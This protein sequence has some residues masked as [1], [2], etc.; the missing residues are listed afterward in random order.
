VENFT[1]T[2]TNT[3]IFAG[4]AREDL[5]RV[6]GNLDEVGVAAGVAILRQG[7]PGD[8]L[9]VVQSGAVEI[10]HASEDGVV[11]RIAILGPC[12]CFGEIALFT[13]APRTATVV[14]LVDT[15]LLRLS[16]ASCE[17]LV[18]QCPAFS[19]HVCRLLGERLVERGRELVQSRAGRD[20][21]LAELFAAQPPATRTLLLMTAVL[22][23]VTPEAL[24][25]VV[26]GQADPGVLD[27]LA[28]RYPR[29]VQADDQGGWTLQ[30]GFRAF[31]LGRLVLDDGA[32][33]AVPLHARVAAHF[34]ARHDWS[35]AV[36]DHLGA[37]AWEAAIH[38]LERHGDAFLAQEA[39]PHVLTQ[40]DALPPALV[41]PRFHLV[42]LRAKAHA[43]QGNLEAALR[44]CRELRAPAHAGSPGAVAQAFGYHVGLAELHRDKGQKAE[45]LRSLRD[46][47]AVL[48][49]SQ[50]RRA[51]TP[52]LRLPRPIIL[53]RHL[54]LQHHWLYVV[55]A[56]AAGLVVWHLPPPAALD[57]AGMRFL[58]TLTVA[59]VLWSVNV[60]DD[61]VVALGL[62]VAWIAAGIVRPEVA[63]S[64]FTKPSWFLFVGALGLGAGVTRS[65]LL[66][67]AALAM[68]R[69]VT[70]SYPRYTAILAAAEVLATPAL[71][72][73]ISRM[74]VV[75]PVS[76][77]IA[78]SVG[79]APR[80][81][82]AAG[83]VFATFVGFSLL[84]FAFLTGS[85]GGLLGW[86]V[87]PEAARVQFGW[88]AWAVAAAPAGV[89][90]L[91]GLWLAIHLLFRLP[92]GG[93][94]RGSR[95]RFQA[96]IEI[97]GPFT[98]REACS[99]GVLVLA[100]TG[101]STTSL[102]G[103]GEAWVA[104]GALLLCLLGGVLDR[105]SLRANVDLGF[106]LF[107][108]VVSSL[109]A[110]VT[111]VQADRWLMTLVSPVLETAAVN[112]T[113]LLLTVALVNI[114]VRFVLNKFAA[115]ILLTL[116]L[117]P[118]GAQL[119]VH[120][121]VVLL[122]IL[123]TTDVWFFPYQLDVYQIAY[124]GTGEQGFTHAQGRQLM[125]AKLVVALVAIVISVP[126]W[127]L[128]GL[129]RSE[130][131]RRGTV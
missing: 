7:D 4:L 99:L 6:A 110:V 42:R 15:S 100:I 101:W 125:V 131:W 107:L 108:G 78:E 96:Q 41:R 8:A 67:R 52:V 38:V 103:V 104:L 127:R 114:T 93:E 86:N 25:P 129:I 102:H 89:I 19:L 83:L 105:G 75:A 17:Q 122:V 113:T 59:L 29:L 54:G 119:G 109:S 63:L 60:F 69:R 31:L 123:L 92:P 3:P 20:A 76:W 121:G 34:E 111:A 47:L 26:D 14:A 74:A 44:G 58:A 10:L 5:A 68:V 91:G 39:P 66:Y 28:E 11:E 9:Y 65:G 98:R 33:A 117:A 55:F 106:L 77:A 35:R 130:Q 37:L 12:E 56:L 62:M 30:P 64:G 61:F 50:A 1:T 80:S 21:V 23:T 116:T 13:G 32:G 112:A 70:P 84:G 124:F 16:K 118:L 115:M 27:D 79:F 53:G 94:V 48:E 97:L 82:G 46:G 87:L 2:I 18:T 128:L 57:T 51:A 90:T 85:T 126:W 22:E 120:P 43:L 40:L 45:A 81:P 49:P 36:D 24:T 88:T 71:P 95:E 72:S 73:M